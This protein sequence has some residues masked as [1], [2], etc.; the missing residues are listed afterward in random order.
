MILWLQCMPGE[1][2]P[3]ADNSDVLHCLPGNNIFIV[4][5]AT[6][7]H[8]GTWISDSQV[9]CRLVASDSSTGYGGAGGAG[10][11]LPIQVQVSN[12]TGE[13]FSCTAC[14]AFHLNV[15]LQET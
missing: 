12:Q 4:I 9:T 10:G 13:T 3:N 14:I 7:G 5:G 1:L 15:D 6:A 2:D 11:G 8:S